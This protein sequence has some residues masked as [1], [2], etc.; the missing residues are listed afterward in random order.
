[1][2]LVITIIVNVISNYD[3]LSRCRTCEG[4]IRIRIQNVRLR[5]GN[6]RIR[7]QNVRLRDTRVNCHLH[8][9]Y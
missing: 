9:G 3:Y 6:I 2:C 7:I 1:M 5:E 4:N 8:D